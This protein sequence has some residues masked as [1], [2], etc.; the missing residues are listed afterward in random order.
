MYLQ[1]V[2]LHPGE[3]RFLE[4]AVAVE[5]KRRGMNFIIGRI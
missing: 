3:S 1:P 5:L 2:D 4:N